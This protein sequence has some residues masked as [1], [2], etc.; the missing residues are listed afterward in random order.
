VHQLTGFGDRDGDGLVDATDKGTP[1]TTCTG[2]VSGACR[3]LDLDFDGDYDSADA[4]L[5]DALPQGLSRYPGRTFSGVHQ[6]F[7]HQGL[8]HDPEIMSYQNRARQ[9][10]PT[11]RRFLQRD[12]IVFPDNGYG[13]ALATYCQLSMRKCQAGDSYS[14][15]VV[16]DGC[17]SFGWLLNYDSGP[18]GRPRFVHLYEYL[19]SNP[20]ILFDPLGQGPVLGIACRL[21]VIIMI[22]E[23]CNERCGPCNPWPDCRRSDRCRNRCRRSRAAQAAL[24]APLICDLL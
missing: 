4:T 17:S 3:L 21:V 18:F 19:D 7:A 12:T 11:K 10:E 14:C 2:T 23:R 15:T 1:G 8:L 22:E 13:D 9:Y 20:T 5:F 16:I 24:F 6:P